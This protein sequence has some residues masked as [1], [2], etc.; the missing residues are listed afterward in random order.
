MNIVECKH[1][2]DALL[3]SR[4]AAVLHK[5]KGVG[6]GVVGW[7]ALAI[8]LLPLAHV[9]R[10]EKSVSLWEFGVNFSGIERGDVRVLQGVGVDLG[11]TDDEG[12]IAGER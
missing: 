8:N 2:Q 7:V 11:T 4:P 6:I 5:V 1:N 9:K 3:V 12:V 10:R